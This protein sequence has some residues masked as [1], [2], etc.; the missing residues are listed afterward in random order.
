M[1]ASGDSE[2]ICEILDYNTELKAAGKVIDEICKVSLSYQGN[3]N[4]D[5]SSRLDRWKDICQLSLELN[6]YPTG[7]SIKEVL[8]LIF[9]GKKRLRCSRHGGLRPA[10]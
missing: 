1:C 7:E 8:G 3:V 6:K 5:S 9:F 10:A 4:E 2:A